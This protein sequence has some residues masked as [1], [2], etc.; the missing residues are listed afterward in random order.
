MTSSLHRSTFCS[1]FT[2]SS[3]TWIE[4]ASKRKQEEEEEWTEGGK[5]RKE[6]RVRWSSVK[7]VKDE[8]GSK[9]L[10]IR[11][12]NVAHESLQVYK[13]LCRK[14]VSDSSDRERVDVAQVL[15]D[16]TFSMT[17]IVK[18]HLHCVYS[19]VSNYFCKC[20]VSQKY[21]CNVCVSRASF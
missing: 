20:S 13:Y 16:S 17:T 7:G 6:N 3:V 4:G 2:R 14:E 11:W 1:V 10:S 21:P 19:Y 18:G 5:K 15:C 8:E 9:M 12:W